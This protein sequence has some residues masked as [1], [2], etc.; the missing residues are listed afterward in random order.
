MHEEILEKVE[1]FKLPLGLSLV[2]LILII[3]GIFASGVDKSPQTSSGQ[4][5]PKESLVFE[6]KLV[7]VDISGAVNTPGVYKFKEGSRI[8]E[9]VAQA[10]GFSDKAN[11][12]YISKSLNMA[13]KL[14]DGSKIYIPFMGET[15]ISGAS[16]TTGTVAGATSVNINTASQS[17]LEALPGVGPVTASKIISNRPYQDIGELLSKKVVGKSVFEK[18]RNSL[19]LY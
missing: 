16:T 17:E 15:V 18:I 2:G 8:E 7:T 6:Q 12:E 1:K 19:V 3:G 14:V 13:Q 9:A 11:Q 5:F 10:G 4:D